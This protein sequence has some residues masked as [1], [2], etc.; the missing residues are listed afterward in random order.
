MLTVWREMK[1]LRTVMGISRTGL[2]FERSSHPVPRC[3][4]AGLGFGS[5]GLWI[6]MGLCFA[7][8]D[9]MQ[10][11]VAVS[12]PRL[13]I[14]E[15]MARNTATL[16]DQDGDMSDWIEI[17]NPGADLINLAGWSLTDEPTAPRKWIFPRTDLRGGEWLMVFASGKNQRKSG[18]EL[19]ANF[20]LS[21][22]GGYLGLF[23]PEGG[24]AESEFSPA[25]PSQVQN[26]SYGIAGGW[27]Q[28]VLVE[29]NAPARFMVPTS[30]NPVS[31]VW[32]DR[33]FDDFAWPSGVMGMGYE[34]ANAEFAPFIRTHVRTRMQNRSETVVIRIP[35]VVENPALLSD[36]RLRIRY[37]DG[38]VAWINGHEAAR[39]NVPETL[40]DSSAAVVDRPRDLAVVPEEFSLRH[41]EDW[42]T[43]GRN[44]LVV[45]GFTQG[46]TDA[47]FL[48]ALALDAAT[49]RGDS[50]TRAYLTNPTPGTRNATGVVEMGPILEAIEHFPKQPM[51]VEALLVRSRVLPTF[52]RVDSVK[53]TYRVLYQ[54]EITV[55]MLDDGAHDEGALGDGVYSA[56]IPGGVAKPGEMIRYFIT[57]TDG[58]GRRSR[59]PV[60]PDPQRSPQYAGTT[61]LNPEVRS[62]L[63]VLEWFIERPTS[64]NNQNGT[65]CSISY[66]GAFFD[67]VGVNTHGQSSLSFPKLS[68]DFDLNTGHHLHWDP[69]APPV[70]DFN[71]LTTYPDKSG[72]RNIL[73]Y[74]VFRDAGAHYHFVF[75]V[76]VQQ[77]GKFFSVAHFV[78]N[79]DD[80][81]LKRLGL[82]PNGALYKV[83]NTLDTTEPTEKKTRKFESKSDLAQLIKGAGQ[84]GVARTRFLYDNVDIPGVVNYLAAMIVTGGNDCCHKNYYVYRDTMNTGLWSFLPWDQDLTFGRNWTGDYYDDRMYPQNGLF[85]GNNNLVLQAL[86]NTPQIRAMY[87]RR[88]R[89]LMEQLLQAPDT[90]PAELLMERRVTEL[91]NLLASD[92]A[93][94]FAKWTTWKQKQTV[95]QAIA[96]LRTN[97]LPAR[98]R[99]LFNTLGGGNN[100]SVPARQ[101]PGAGVEIR[102]LDFSPS[103]ANQEQ[104]YIELFNTNRL[105]LDV[106]GWF[107]RGSVAH[108][109]QAGTVIPQSNSLFL[110]ARLT[111]FR[112]RTNGPTSGQG[113]FV[114]GD[115]KG[116]LSARGGKL[117]I[118]NST[119][120]VVG[121]SE[122]VGNA[123]TGQ[124]FLRI[125]QLHFHPDA[126]PE[127]P[128]FEASDFEF[129]E[130]KNIGPETVRLAGSRLAGG[131]QFGFSSTR[132]PWLRPG[133]R[134]YVVRNEMAFLA[135]YGYGYAVAGE[136]DGGLGDGGNRVELYES[137]GELVLD[138][139][140]NDKWY[141]E[142]DGRGRSLVAA[143][144]KSEWIAWR[145]QSGWKSSAERGG[146]LF[147]DWRALH[148]DVGQA[149]DATADPDQDGLSNAA[150]FGA[151]TDPQ[152]GGSLL[153]LRHARDPS[154]SL[155]LLFESAANRS[156]SIQAS[157][158]L[159]GPWRPIRDVSASLSALTID[160]KVDFGSAS[161]RYFRVVTP[162]G[163]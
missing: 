21:V 10:A 36:L 132:I 161:A 42:L 23:P 82:D 32:F 14:A 135:R 133:E 95:P 35:F 145:F 131:V 126:V 157:E 20:R 162:G 124:R 46:R 80:N 74:E 53:L 144:E 121:R 122:F 3:V 136:F 146:D 107:L 70:D 154:G 52:G 55:P 49:P 114:Q 94:D 27:A 81:Y 77:N 143:N 34:A 88:V 142:A 47:D 31:E 104:E 163:Q 38:F 89:S 128:D 98:R 65:R 68:Y 17:H 153:R 26:V 102:S 130:I 41:Q 58:D 43:P 129:I 13:V 78:E 16:V 158:S 152:D 28:V 119:G 48:M 19:H 106:S 103:S 147:N 117:E 69:S 62:P 1:L 30:E 85:I 29:T 100:P 5:V 115:Y 54:P 66:A 59:F 134:V 72:V 118:V 139:S 64:A 6:C 79:G 40:D 138:F 12:K 25:Y 84:S 71:L 160:L 15:F 101:T 60:Y 24:A 155:A 109:F 61:V 44:M 63:P 22:G 11:E 110:G 4:L 127:L 76:R 67:N 113:L 51:A 73:A 150:E 140:Y 91:E 156:Y 37:D 39:S 56:S 116:R 159:S 125:T 120:L 151:G 93:L 111:A 148:F 57:A 86:F 96:I 141:P 108:T 112:T 99:F 97:Y 92:A 75:P 149:A 18:G 137:T 123:T 33:E 105:A 50:E 7:F 90:A 9:G 8:A 45:Q 87:L 2:E 83:Y